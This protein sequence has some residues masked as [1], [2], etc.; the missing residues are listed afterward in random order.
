MKGSWRRVAALFL[1][2]NTPL[3]THSH[4]H[5]VFFFFFSPEGISEKSYLE[6]Y[7]KCWMKFL[8]HELHAHT[9]R[10]ILSMLATGLFFW[11]FPSAHTHPNSF[12]QSTNSHTL[13][14]IFTNSHNLHNLSQSSQT[15]TIFTTSHNLHKLS[16]SPHSHVL[17]SLTHSHKP[18]PPL[19]M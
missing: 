1:R 16:Q 15:L 14:T 4:P 10:D 13:T 2:L 5:T 19:Q 7:D 18:L 11:L 17:H 8:S 9:Y 6:Q 12:S 3:F